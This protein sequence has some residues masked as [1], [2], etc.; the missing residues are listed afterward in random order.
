M[1]RLKLICLGNNASKLIQSS[2][3]GSRSCR[4]FAFSFRLPFT[5]PW[6]IFIPLLPHFFFFIS[7]DN[8]FPFKLIPNSNS[9]EFNLLLIPST[10]IFITSSYSS[11]HKFQLKKPLKKNAS[12]HRF[13]ITFLALFQSDTYLPD[14]IFASFSNFAS[15]TLVQITEKNIENSWAED[16]KRAST[17]R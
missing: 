11:F 6:F 12:T 4:K 13:S 16:R 7:N 5:W 1:H 14:I 8:F 10:K 15:F 2:E 9:I 17:G 3:F